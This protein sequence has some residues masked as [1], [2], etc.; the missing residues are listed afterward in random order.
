[1]GRRLDP[2]FMLLLI[3]PIAVALLAMLSGNAGSEEATAGPSPVASAQVLPS[4]TAAAASAPAP[5]AVEPTAIPIRLPAVVGRPGIDWTRLERPAAWADQELTEIYAG[6]TGIVVAGSRRDPSRPLATARFV[7]AATP[8]RPELA[9]APAIWW[10]DDGVSWQDVSPP[11]TGTRESAISGLVAL[12]HGIAAFGWYEDADLATRTAVWLSA[13]G[14]TWRMLETPLPN[15]P[16]VAAA[17]GDRVMAIVT[18]PMGGAPFRAWSTLD[19]ASWNEGGLQAGGF[20]Y[21]A[22]SVAIR[23]GR[24][25]LFG[26]TSIRPMDQGWG[27][28]PAF[29]VTRDGLSWTPVTEVTGLDGGVIRVAADLGPRLVAAGY[30]DAA[31]PSDPR[32]GVWYGEDLPSWTAATLPKVRGAS[33]ERI[34]FVLVDD[35]IVLLATNAA[36]RDTALRSADG[37]TWALLGDARLPAGSM[38]RVV[39]SGDAVLAVA[40][41]HPDAAA[42]EPAGSWLWVAPAAT[43]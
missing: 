43:R 42:G 16:L 15:S 4:A 34:E 37:R 40:F 17:I 31:G 3:G 20:P 8:Q 33:Y 19:F 11:P 18:L 30:A 21:P 22:G 38:S 28:V 2:V 6:S 29:W 36:G 25:V 39:R 27:G 41:V 14:R 24:A 26:R 12:P 35:G 32:L 13:D 23:D 7:L 9:R 1:M 10:S 5:S